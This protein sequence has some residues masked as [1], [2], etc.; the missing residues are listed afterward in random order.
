MLGNES[1]PLTASGEA[2]TH[3]AIE[4]MNR[5][6]YERYKGFFEMHDGKDGYDY[7]IIGI[8]NIIKRYYT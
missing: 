7:L 8:N 1:N 4:L 3:P 2:R 5:D 6:T